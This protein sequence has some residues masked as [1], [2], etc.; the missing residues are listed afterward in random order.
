MWSKWEWRRFHMMAIK[1]TIFHGLES[2]KVDKHSKKWCLARNVNI[3]QCAK[4]SKGKN[5]KYWVYS[6]KR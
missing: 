6:T 2:K 5:E 3:G 1:Q 4:E